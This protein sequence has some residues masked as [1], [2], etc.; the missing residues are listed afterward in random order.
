MMWL[1]LHSIRFSSQRIDAVNWQ[2]C[3]TTETF[4]SFETKEVGSIAQYGMLT[5]NRK[6]GL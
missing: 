5:I 2:Y 4:I 1:P 3:T 6:G